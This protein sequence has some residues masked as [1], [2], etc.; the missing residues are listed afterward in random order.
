MKPAVSLLLLAVFGFAAGALA[1][2]RAAS[3]SAQLIR[4]SDQP[5][6]HEP[7]WRPVEPKL[8]AQLHPIFRWKHYW[9]VTSAKVSVLPGKSKRVRLS[10]Q[11]D[12]EIELLNSKEAEVRLYVE[13]KLTRKCRQRLDLR[14]DKWIMGGTR[15]N[16]ESWFI[17]VTPEQRAA[18][19]QASRE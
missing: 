14:K 7:T 4:G 12:I 8:L 15:D 5:K 18:L 10:H 9:E 13:G 6:P 2:D 3:F 17:V 11:R 19:L 1:E 16:D